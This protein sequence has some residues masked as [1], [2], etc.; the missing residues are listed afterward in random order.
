M[1]QKQVIRS[2]NWTLDPQKDHA[3][4]SGNWTLDQQK[5]SCARPGVQTLDRLKR[6]FVRSCTRSLNTIAHKIVKINVRTK[7]CAD[8]Q[9]ISTWNVSGGGRTTARPTKNG[10]RPDYSKKNW[11]ISP[12]RYVPCKTYL[13]QGTTS[14]TKLRTFLH[15]ES[16]C[17]KMYVENILQK[18][19][20]CTLHDECMIIVF[21]LQFIFVVS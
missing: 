7:I 17:C 8:A 14:C 6:L 12:E 18:Y 4:R 3:A 9:T 5:S 2:G 19:S 11:C 15:A 21:C 13:V 20:S 16:A 1:G 10:R